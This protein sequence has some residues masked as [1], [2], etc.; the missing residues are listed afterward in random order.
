M[1]QYEITD[2]VDP[3]DQ[4]SNGDYN[5]D[6]DSDN[7]YVD[8]SNNGGYYSYTDYSNNGGAIYYSYDASNAEDLVSE[9]EADEDLQEE[10]RESTTMPDVNSNADGKDDKE[11]ESSHAVNDFTST[12]HVN[13]SESESMQKDL[14]LNTTTVPTSATLGHGVVGGPYYAPR[15]TTNNGEQIDAPVAKHHQ[16][17]PIN[18]TTA[19]KKLDAGTAYQPMSTPVI[20]QSLSHQ[21]MDSGAKHVTMTSFLIGVCFAVCLRA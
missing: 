8:Y 2:E 12:D 15:P 20:R 19:A 5:T 7:T 14:D 21:T 11:L 9:F 1:E 10:V 6:Y 18:A 13:N 3:V 4:Y 16:S 17:K